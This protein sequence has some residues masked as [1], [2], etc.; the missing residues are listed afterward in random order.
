MPNGNTSR[1]HY[2][3]LIQKTQRVKPSRQLLLRGKLKDEALVGCI[4]RRRRKRCITDLYPINVNEVPRQGTDGCER[5]TNYPTISAEK[6]AK[7]PELKAALSTLDKQ[8]GPPLS[9]VPPCKMECST[10]TPLPA[11]N[12][13]PHPGLGC[14]WRCQLS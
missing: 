1:Q 3:W 4:V 8:V 9:L 7:R 10:T 5:G 11:L 13:G 12:E 2:G 14:L 6:L